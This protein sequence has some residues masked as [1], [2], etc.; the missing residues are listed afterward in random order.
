MRCSRKA[1]YRRQGRWRVI[2]TTQNLW[3][4]VREVRFECSQ[5]RNRLKPSLLP[6]LS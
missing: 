2:P 5:R 3:F 4:E 1:S 6:W